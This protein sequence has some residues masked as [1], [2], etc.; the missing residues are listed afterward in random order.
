VEKARKRAI[1]LLMLRKTSKGQNRHPN[2]HRPGFE[3]EEVVR[4]EMECTGSE[5]ERFFLLISACYFSE[6][7]Q[8]EGTWRS[9][10]RRARSRQHCLN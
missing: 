10:L 1:K 3:E 9:P 5:P 2:M 6:L 8:V 4:F 7:Q